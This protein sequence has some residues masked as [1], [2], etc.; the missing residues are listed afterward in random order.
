MWGTSVGYPRRESS[1]STSKNYTRRAQARTGNRQTKN[2]EKSY[3]WDGEGHTK[4]ERINEP[5]RP[6]NKRI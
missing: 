4:G 5:P 6:S 2:R 3:G 1:T